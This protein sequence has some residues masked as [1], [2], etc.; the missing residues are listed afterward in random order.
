MPR[1]S[2][3]Q[4]TANREALVRA[5]SALLREQG[6]A[7]LTLDAVA[8]RAGLTHG[9]FYKQF[10]SRDALIAEA[11]D[12]AAAERR[13]AVEALQAAEGRAA[14]IDWYLSPAHR[15]APGDGCAVAALA[16]EA[17]HAPAGP[18][19]DGIRSAIDD[20]VDA[21]QRA[22]DDSDAARADAL[23]EVAMMV[24]ALEL[25]RATAGTPI[26]DELLAAA[27]ARLS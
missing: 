19:G 12:H 7:A 2:R 6:P 13:G 10:A 16:G 21:R 20:L 3:A 14:V 9:G 25:A 15:D 22:G 8:S 1:T 18:L 5:A 24:G 11:V 4:T 17:A 26:S 23:A 27:R